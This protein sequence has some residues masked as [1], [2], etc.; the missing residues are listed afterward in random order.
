[1]TI[2]VTPMI[3]DRRGKLAINHRSHLT[4]LFQDFELQQPAP[5]DRRTEQR[6]S[7][8]R[9]TGTDPFGRLGGLRSQR[10]GQRTDAQSQSS[11]RIG[12][13]P[14]H[15]RQERL[16][17][18]RFFRSLPRFRHLFGPLEF[19][20]LHLWRQFDRTELPQRPPT[21]HSQRRCF[22]RV[23]HLEETQTDATVRIAVRR[24]DFV[25]EAQTFQRIAREECQF[26]IQDGA[27]QRCHLILHQQ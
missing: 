11:A 13:D 22:R 1:V 9:E 10:L 27:T 25:E 24:L 3:L 2:L 12:G 4:L 21:G 19:S 5:P 26:I 18:R 23:R 14:E 15:L 17:R 8:A 7:G 16:L 20:E 6:G